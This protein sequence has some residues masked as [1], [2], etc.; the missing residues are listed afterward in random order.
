[1]E[2]NQHRDGQLHSNFIALLVHNEGWAPA[3]GSTD[4]MHAGPRGAVFK[5][6]TNREHC[7]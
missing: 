4:P 2:Y 6:N 7:H 3:L 5:K 1:M